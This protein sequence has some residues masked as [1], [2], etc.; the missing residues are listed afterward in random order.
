MFIEIITENGTYTIGKELTL[1][2]LF[3]KDGKALPSA[4]F[5]CD[6]IQEDNSSEPKIKF[7]GGGFGHGVGMSQYGAGKMGQAGLNFI[8][9]LKHYY[10][11]ISIGTIPINITSEYGKN[12]ASQTFMSPDGKAEIVIDTIKGVKE[13]TIIV[14]GLET[15][16]GLGKFFKKTRIDI[17]KHLNKGINTVEFNIPADC[18]GEKEMTLHIEIQGER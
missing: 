12:V 14:N 10:T 5:V 3:K 7:T 1:R 9:I 11:G 15:D 13:F 17:S 8:S 2:R 18:N 4:N 16:L 6:I